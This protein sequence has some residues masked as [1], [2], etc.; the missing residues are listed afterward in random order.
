MIDN[1][2]MERDFEI[3]QQI[4]RNNGAE[5]LVS[6]K[7]KTSNTAINRCNNVWYLQTKKL[8]TNFLLVPRCIK[9]DVLRNLFY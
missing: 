4:I 6:V 9:G 8:P 5:I 3:D 7:K 1:P 2:D